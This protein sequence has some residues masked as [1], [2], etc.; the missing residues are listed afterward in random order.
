MSVNATLPPTQYVD[1]SG[2][3]RGMNIDLGNEIAKR[4]CLRPV[5]VNVAF[6]AQIPG[7]QNK[8]WDM[9]D[10]GLYFTLSRTKTMQLIPYSVGSLAIV[11]ASGNPRKISAVS[12]LSGKIVGVEF[13]G[14]EE[15]RLEDM[16]AEI[17]RDHA[18]S[19]DIRI[20]N[21]YGDAFGALA[22]GQIDAV[23]VGADVGKYYAQRGSFEVA[24]SDLSPQA[25]AALAT[26]DV[27]IATA[28]VSALSDMEADG[29]YQ[30]IITRYGL[31]PINKWQGYPGHIQY[32]YKP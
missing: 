17:V 30:T 20:F 10:T 2:S 11:T 9:M 26:A 3:L 19:V 16:A 12:D 1:D 22:A 18:K 27:K 15:K 8:R 7:L 32:F 25:P 13:G 29:T 28:I 31:T 6:E 21:N 24:V 14:I 5:Y 4:L 23:F